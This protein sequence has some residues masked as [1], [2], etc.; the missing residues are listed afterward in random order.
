MLL[1]A[2]ECA[3]SF[4]VTPDLRAQEEEKERELTWKHFL[5]TGNDND[6]DDDG[7]CNVEQALRKGEDDSFVD[8]L[9]KI[10]RSGVPAALRGEVCHS[11]ITQ[12]FC[13]NVFLFLERFANAAMAGVLGCQGATRTR[14]GGI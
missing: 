12:F 14:G 10:V 11:F 13:P 3:S 1:N 9:T 5:N 2:F 8:E 6:S 7:F 4:A